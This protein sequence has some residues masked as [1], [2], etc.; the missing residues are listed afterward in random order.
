MR[1]LERIAEVVSEALISKVQHVKLNAK[2]DSGLTR[3]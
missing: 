1:T 2:P 3:P